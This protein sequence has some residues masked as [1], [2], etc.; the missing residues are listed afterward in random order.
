MK[1]NLPEK[2][3]GY[4]QSVRYLNNYGNLVD[5]AGIEEGER[6]ARIDEHQPNLQVK[7]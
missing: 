7:E 1:K 2:S 4:K 5:K 3:I 6:G